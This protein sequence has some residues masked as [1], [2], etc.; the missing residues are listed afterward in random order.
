MK[1]RKKPIVVEAFRWGYEKEP[2]WFTEKEGTYITVL[3]DDRQSR[4]ELLIPT[5]EGTMHAKI[6][7][8][9]IRGIKGEIYPCDSLI[10]SMTYERVIEND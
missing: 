10:F 2:E 4:E 5:I 9:I 6:G 7:D 1:Y 3:S 8:Y